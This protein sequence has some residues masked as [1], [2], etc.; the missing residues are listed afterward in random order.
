ML[1]IS[2]Q[3][4]K[5]LTADCHL[6]TVPVFPAKVNDALVLPEQMVVPPVTVP[7]AEAGE[8]VI[9]PVAFALPQPVG[10]MV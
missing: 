6:V 7:P 2:V 10:V 5:G 3:V 4:A 1:T 9:V 8:T